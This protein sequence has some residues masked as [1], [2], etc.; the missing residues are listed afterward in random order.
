MGTGFMAGIV[1]LV[2]TINGAAAHDLGQYHWRHR[3][4]FLVASSSED[5]GIATQRQWVQRRW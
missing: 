2:E 4:L 5:P 3:L 1:P